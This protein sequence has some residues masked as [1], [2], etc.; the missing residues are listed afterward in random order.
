MTTPASLRFVWLRVSLDAFQTLTGIGSPRQ[1]LD[2]WHTPQQTSL[3]GLQLPQF[4]MLT[5]SDL[6]VMSMQILC[7]QEPLSASRVV[8]DTSLCRGLHSVTT[9]TSST[10]MLVIAR[11]DANLLDIAILPAL[12]GTNVAG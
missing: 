12:R 7:E 4:S 6:L 1:Y 9:D 8:N 5:M 2:K 10:T 3:Q 11:L